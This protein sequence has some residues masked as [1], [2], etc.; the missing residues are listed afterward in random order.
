MKKTLIAMFA[1]CGVCAAAEPVVTTYSDLLANPSDWTQAST[2][3]RDL[4]SIED[5]VF[6]NN[7][8]NW[9]Q[10]YATYTF[11]TAPAIKDAGDTFDFSYMLGTGGTRNACVTLTLIDTIGNKALT[12]GMGNYNDDPGAVKFGTSELITISNGNIYNFQNDKITVAGTIATAPETGFTN[13]VGAITMNDGK[14][15]ASFGDKSVE[16]GD[17]FTVDKMIITYDCGSSDTT[18]PTLGG[19][20][21]TFTDVAPVPEPA[22]A[23]LSLLALAGLAA[24]RRRH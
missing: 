23:T 7:I 10:D 19:L 14:A 6:Y 24:R 8:C 16:L 17:S 18:R 11:T 9:G 1:L 2:R 4:A 20:N 3:D 21:A 13:I 12:V 22:T 5:S 15:V